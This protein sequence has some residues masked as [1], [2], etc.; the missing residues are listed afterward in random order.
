MKQNL[1]ICLMFIGLT[2]EAL[3]AQIDLTPTIFVN[4]GISVPYGPHNF[5]K[6]W[7]SGFNLGG[8]AEF[9]LNPSLALQPYFE[10]NTMPVDKAK[11]NMSNSNIVGGNV[12]LYTLSLNFKSGGIRPVDGPG[13]YVIGGL[14]LFQ[15]DQS[16]VVGGPGGAVKD[17]GMQVG[18]GLI[19]KISARYGFFAEI[20]YSVGFIEGDNA[21]Y[22][23]L[24]IGIY[25]EPED[26]KK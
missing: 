6:Y 8:G 15:L 4:S 22:L 2:S 9:L 19:N 16:S 24:K 3:F 10:Y 5:S 26:S 21:Q 13:M 12:S 1:F 18:L 17:L 7:N 20:K 14:G 25:F 11:L 23:P